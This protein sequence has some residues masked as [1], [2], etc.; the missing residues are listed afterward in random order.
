MSFTGLLF[1]LFLLEH[2]LGNLIM[3]AGRDA[4]NTYVY[5]LTKYK[6]IQ[7]TAEVFFVLFFGIHIVNGIKL[8]IEN[9]KARKTGYHKKKI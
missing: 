7:Y 1:F 6:W 3:F 2:L 4:Y 9:Y 8:T 5:V